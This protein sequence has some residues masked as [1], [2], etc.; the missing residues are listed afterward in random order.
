[1]I[2]QPPGRARATL[3]YDPST[4]LYIIMSVSLLIRRPTDGSFN[5]T[6]VVSERTNGYLINITEQVKKQN[7]V[8]RVIILF[9]LWLYLQQVLRLDHRVIAL[10]LLP[11][12]NWDMSSLI[13]HLYLH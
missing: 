1:M 5:C 2:L 13:T 12:G 7:L 8:N 11:L 10:L 9:I 3:A 6:S 4:Y